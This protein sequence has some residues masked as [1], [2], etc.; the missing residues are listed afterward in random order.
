MDILS[1]IGQLKIYKQLKINQMKK[2]VL[3]LMVSC[4]LL[5]FYP[6]QSSAETKTTPSSLVADKP[7]ESARA[8]ALLLRLDEIKS[9]DKSNLKS[10][11]KK[12]LRKEV[13]SIK[14][15]LRTMHGGLYISV[16]A[17]I[18]IV[19]ILILLL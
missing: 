2:F 8:K 18:L 6:I 11:D 15:E 9:M 17:A 3:C 4:M 12:V 10:S 19:L 7:A 5:A 16:G 14:N 13:R 1:P